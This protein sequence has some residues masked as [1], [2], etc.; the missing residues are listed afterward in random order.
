MLFTINFI[1]LHPM[2]CW[3]NWQKASTTHA[4]IARW[5]KHNDFDNFDS[6][7]DGINT[8][9]DINQCRWDGTVNHFSHLDNENDMSDLS[10]EWEDTDGNEGEQKE[11][12]GWSVVVAQLMDAD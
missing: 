6:D 8:G 3:K 5:K 10:D 2:P 12:G 4:R 11:F 9:S 1:H 7:A